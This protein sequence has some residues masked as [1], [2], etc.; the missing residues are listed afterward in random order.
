MT[1]LIEQEHQVR[2]FEKFVGADAGK[3]LERVIDPVGLR[4]FLEVLR[5]KVN[6]I[7]RVKG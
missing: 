1:N 5:V 3:Q 7:I 2:I 4:V 6:I